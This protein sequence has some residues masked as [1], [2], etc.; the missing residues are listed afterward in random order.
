[1]CGLIFQRDQIV[2]L[3]FTDPEIK[4]NYRTGQR[5]W[6]DQQEEQENW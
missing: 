4:T 3:W 5:E 6:T 2:H 1:M